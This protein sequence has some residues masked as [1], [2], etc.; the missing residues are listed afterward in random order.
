MISYNRK[1]VTRD[2]RI[3]SQSKKSP[4]VSLSQPSVQSWHSGMFKPEIRSVAN[5]LKSCWAA[6]TAKQLRTIKM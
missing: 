3:V 4:V 6:F 5:L 2:Q 1:G